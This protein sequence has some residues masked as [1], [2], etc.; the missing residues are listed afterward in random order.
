MPRRAVRAEGGV[1]FA[2]L[3]HETQAFGLAAP[4]G[5][6]SPTGIGGLTLG[7]WMGWLVRKHG[8]VCDN[9]VAADVVTADGQLR[10]ASAD[11][12]PD[13]FWALRGAGSTFGVVTS[14]EYALHPLGPEVWQLAVMYSAIAAKR[15]LRVFREHMSTAPEELG[16]LA[17]F[18]NV[19][20]EYFIPEEVR[21]V[22]AIVLLGCYT[23]PLEQGEEALRPL[24][25]I[26]NPLV[27]LTSRTPYVRAQ[28]FFDADYPS[29]GL[30]YWKSRFLKSLDDDVIDFLPMARAIR[31]SARTSGAT[32]PRTC[33]W[34]VSPFRR[35]SEADEPLPICP[36]LC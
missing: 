19:P 33:S 11:E 3:D 21:G 30:Y 17:V 4:G 10:R 9:L 5:L 27:D 34:A 6:V 20:D 29:G 12:E 16:A 22:P 13:L 32:I 35:E 2:D 14:F 31:G 15:V 7:G 18:W 23:G 25:E 28:Q 24:R 26:G 36:C 1:R 8:L